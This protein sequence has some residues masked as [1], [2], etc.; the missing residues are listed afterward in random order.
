MIKILGVE[1]LPAKLPEEELIGT[2]FGTVI[3]RA[4]PLA[5]KPAF[6]LVSPISPLNHHKNPTIT[7]HHHNIRHLNHEHDVADL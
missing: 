6:P 4:R 5:D 2:V 7:Q 1:A 3:G